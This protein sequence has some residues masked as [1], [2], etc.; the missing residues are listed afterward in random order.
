MVTQL[1]H[2]DVLRVVKI[3][4]AEDWRVLSLN[5]YE[6]IIAELA[7]RRQVDIERGQLKNQRL[8]LDPWEGRYEIALRKD[9]TQKLHAIVW[10]AGPDAE[11]GTVDD[12]VYPPSDKGLRPM[13]YQRH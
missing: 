7:K 6:T 11:H 12:I 5:E 9:E 4:T 8:L 1:T 2:G 3:Q 13:P 10:S